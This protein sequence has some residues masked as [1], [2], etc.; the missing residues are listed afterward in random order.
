MF[1]WISKGFDGVAIERAASFGEELRRLRVHAGLTQEELAERAGITAQAIGALERGDRRR[2]YPHTVRSLSAALGLSQPEQDALIRLVRAVETEPAPPPRPPAEPITAL[3]VPPTPLFGRDQVRQEVSDLLSRPG[4][5]LITMTGPGGVGK[6]RLAVEIAASSAAAFPDSVVLVSLASLTDYTLVVPAIAQAFGI[7]EASGRSV[8]DAL[9]MNLANKR[10]LLVL[11]NFEHVLE[12]APEIAELLAACNELKLLVTSRSPLRLRGEQEFPVPPLAVPGVGAI[13]PSADVVTAFASVVLFVA[14]AQ[15]ADPSFR[16][17][18]ANA[19]AVA[20][21]C[22]RLDGLPL[23][24]E[25]AAARIK[26]FS[27]EALL[28]RLQNRLTLLTGGARDLPDRQRTMRDAIAWSFGLLSPEEQALFRRLGVFVGGFTLD[29]A[30]S[31]MAGFSQPRVDVIDA[32]ASLVDKS[33]L[34]SLEGPDGGT[35]FGMLET[36]REYALEQ[37]EREGETAV[38][39][40]RHADYFV[41]VAEHA[42]VPEYTPEEAMY[43]RRLEPEFP[44]V[45]T[46]LGWL[47]DEA[48]AELDGPRRALRL[49]GAMTRFW[50][51]RGYLRESHTWIERALNAAPVEPSYARAVALTALGIIAWWVGDIDGALNRQEEAL[52]IWRELDE[53]RWIVSSLWFV[54]LVA[55]KLGNTAQMEELAKEADPLISQ[56]GVTLW[57]TVPSSLRAMAALMRGDRAGTEE[58]FAPVL[59]Y[60]GRNNFPWAHAWVLGMFAEAALLE[61]DH[62][63]AL[64]RFQASLAEFNDHGD[65]YATIDGLIAVASQAAELGQ[66]AT[67]ARLLGAESV[68]RAAI[69]NRVTWMS[70]TTSETVELTRARLGAEAFDRAFNEGRALCLADAVDLALAVQPGEGSRG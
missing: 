64:E 67:A 66:A 57:A 3:P 13:T 17:T 4:L 55:A 70:V 62:A 34:R 38:A 14:R 41:A 69:G 11:D 1:G 40:D 16:L 22:R 35:R 46:A 30:E 20:E 25:L 5:R 65:V 26:L 63:A 48:P 52:A 23:A 53:R 7:R 28:D 32:I 27:P 59:A 47:L 56:I 50:G 44:N 31:V 6:T 9:R 39:H 15:A 24:I 42:A 54:G 29:A 61:R 36:I 18:D 58:Y 51:I 37:L 45:R 10:L 19:P 8:R 2:P 33:L 68:V 12:A 60:Q 43:A 21:I 49:A